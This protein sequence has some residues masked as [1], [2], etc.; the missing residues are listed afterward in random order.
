VVVV[1]PLGC[2][3]GYMIWKHHPGSK[4]TYCAAGIDGSVWFEASEY[5]GLINVI[6][7]AIRED[8]S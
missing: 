5:T 2:H 6:D 7:E 1:M 3:E 4:A 8:S